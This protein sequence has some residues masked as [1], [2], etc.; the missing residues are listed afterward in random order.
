MRLT[1]KRNYPLL[2]LLVGVLLVLILGMGKQR[3][4]AYTVKSSQAAQSQ[5]AD[6]YT[7]A[8]S[9]FDDRVVHTLQIEMDPIDYQKMITT[10]QQTGE[11][12]YFHANI[13]IDGVKVN[14]VGIRL[15]GNASL[16][17]ALGVR[18]GRD[19]RAPG[20]EDGGGQLPAGGMPGG[21]RN[22]QIP[23]MI[24]FDE[25]VSGQTYQSYDRFAI[26]SSG[27]SYDASLLQEPIT[28]SV[29]RSVGLPATGTAYA[30]LSLNGAEEK[31][32]TISEV[33]EQDYL[34]KRFTNPGG[35]LYK[36]EVR[37]NMSYLGEDPSAYADSFTI[38]TRINDADMAPLI[39]FLKFVSQSDDATF[40]QDLPKY[41]DVDSFATYLAVNSLLVNNDSMVGI[42]NNF[43][44][45]YDDQTGRFTVLLWDANESLGKLG[46][47]RP[48]GGGSAATADIYPQASMRVGGFPGMRGASNDLLNRF[49]ANETFKA[50][51]EQ[52]L[53]LVYQQA[54]ANG[55]MAQ[56]I[57]QYTTLVRKANA[58]RHLVDADAYEQ[59]VANVINFINQ[60]GEYLASIPLLGGKTTAQK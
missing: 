14:N 6:N 26:R 49:M 16:G 15:K 32:F 3:I 18:F 27:I 25:F 2:I 35:V 44:L 40:E 28:Y 59:A 9:L 30:G 13:V 48:G 45:Y 24:K 31:L 47:G 34:E 12:D 57:E 10:Y 11:K 42:G 39:R 21:N 17:T 38:E 33:I 1:L 19:Q 20:G 8:V 36:S 46:F 54:F 58:D 5:L 56:Q 43:Y 50:L 55:G 41:L 53:K 52:K 60:R 4:I 29:L 22:T 51:Y 23:L 7:N 37:S